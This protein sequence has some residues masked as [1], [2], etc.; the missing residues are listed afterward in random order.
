M[1]FTKKVVPSIELF[2]QFFS[3]WSL[4]PTRAAVVWSWHKE[5][6]L[7]LRGTLTVCKRTPKIFASLNRYKSLL[8]W[9]KAKYSVLLMRAYY[10][11]VVC[12]EMRKRSEKS[13]KAVALNIFCC[14]NNE[15]Q[16]LISYRSLNVFKKFSCRNNSM[17]LYFQQLVL[18][19]FS[20]Y[21]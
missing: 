5:R 21:L 14:H 16:L 6:C 18:L 20:L 19:L 7:P 10:C 9:R 1:F 11:I 2:T 13:L 4:V 3:A 12:L 8:V 17:H 15:M